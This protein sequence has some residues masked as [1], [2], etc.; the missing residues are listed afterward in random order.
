MDNYLLML[1]DDGEK[2]DDSSNR[3][4]IYTNSKKTLNSLIRNPPLQR[5][6]RQ[7]RRR[8]H[9]LSDENCEDLFKAKKKKKNKSD[10]ANNN[11]SSSNND[12][13]DEE[14]KRCS[15]EC[16]KKLKIG[17]SIF[18]NSTTLYRTDFSDY[19]LITNSDFTPYIDYAPKSLINELEGRW[20]YAMH[21]SHG[22]Q[23]SVNRNILQARVVGGEILAYKYTKCS[24][25]GNECIYYG[26]VPTI[27]K[28]INNSENDDIDNGGSSDFKD[29]HRRC[30]ISMKAIWPR[31]L[32]V[33]I[34]REFICDCSPG[35]S[36]WVVRLEDYKTE[37]RMCVKQ[38][39][40]DRVYVIMGDAA[41]NEHGEDGIKVP[42]NCVVCAQ[43]FDCSQSIGFCRKHRVCKHKRKDSFTMDDIVNSK[44]KTCK[45]AH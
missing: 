37:L 9:D 36:I 17:N 26:F 15:V 24:I 19:T 43:C 38:I 42:R 32:C 44:M 5:R 12:D 23:L 1:N 21:I 14:K 16:G 40:W 33:Y 29:T 3:L 2:V 8:F 7:Q 39:P 4:P 30:R 13:V 20:F 27:L 18:L 11:S 34:R 10:D 31:K 22:M 25:E 28:A 45:K 35:C 41:D 6:K